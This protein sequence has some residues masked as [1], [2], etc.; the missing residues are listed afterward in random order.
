MTQRKGGPAATGWDRATIALAVVFVLLVAGIAVYVLVEF[1]PQSA[2]PTSPPTPPGVVPRGPPANANLTPPTALP[3]LLTDGRLGVDV[4]ADQRLDSQDAAAINTTGARMVRWPGG[5]L[6]DRFDPLGDSDAGTIYTVNGTSVS[7]ATSYPE[8]VSWCG[9]V[10]CQSIVTLPAEIDNATLAAAIVSYSVHTLHF[11]PTYWEIG[12][13]PLMWTH[14]GI[15]WT[16][17]NLTQDVVARPSSFASL[18]QS[19]VASIR[20]VD[21]T[22]PILGIGGVGAGGSQSTWITDDVATNGPNLTGVAIHVY[23]AGNINGPEPPTT[24]LASL[25]SG[26]ALPTR[27]N[28]TLSEVNATCPTCHLD[29]LADE[30]GTGT[31]V[32]QGDE[33]T[34]GYL[35][36][37]VSAEILQSLPLRLASA[38]YY[39]LESETPGAWF[40]PSGAPSPAYFAYSN[41]AEQVGSYAAP[42]G[43]SSKATGLLAAVGGASAGTL[44]NLILVNVNTSFTFSLNLSKDFADVAEASILTWNGS[45]GSPSNLTWGPA[46]PTNLTVPPMSLAILSNVGASGALDRPLS[47]GHREGPHQGIPIPLRTESRLAPTVL[48]RFGG[49]TSTGIARE[50]SLAAPALPARGIRTRGP[51]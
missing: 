4:R 7:P 16:S 39:N 18:V 5:A 15:P 26:S 44:T 3:V 2:S 47:S 32:P 51:G 8:F 49:L 12:N 36:T 35:A 11:F 1:P 24:W 46:G 6:G 23:P 30:L 9:W 10:R 45:S 27:V 28:S 19:Y 33:I 43:V 34:G 42:L 37:Y 50:P 38:D 14:F 29:V 48:S 31:L 13:E 22:T 25:Q 20:S 40:S 17:W 41:W 21:P